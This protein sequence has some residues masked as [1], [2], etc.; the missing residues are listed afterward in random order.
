[1]TDSNLPQETIDE[2]NEVMNAALLEEWERLK[3][4]WAEAWKILGPEVAYI[5]GS[6]VDALGHIANSLETLV[7]NLPEEEE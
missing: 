2:I 5:Y 6:T 1:M 4:A 7:E 3:S